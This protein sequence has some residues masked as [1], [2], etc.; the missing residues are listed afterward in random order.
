MIGNS[1]L[2]LLCLAASVLL[3]GCEE[4][5]KAL[6]QTKESPDEFAVFQRAP[7]SRPPDY[8]LRPPSPGAQ[9]PQAVN[10][11]DRARAVLGARQQSEGRGTR[12]DT[13]RLSAGERAVL[14]LTGAT[15]ANPSIR[16]QVNKETSALVAE[17][18]SVTDKIVFW[19]KTAKFGVSVDPTKESKRLRENQALG[20]PL[21]SGKVPTIKR[22]R[23]ALF[24]GIL[25]K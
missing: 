11:R 1:K 4:T 13:S 21:T 7:L 3:T 19:Q 9:R 8:N 14:K 2:I 23:S 22:K 15:D 17:S 25:P 5:K 10:P 6:G 24:E 12:A 18:K 20:R 16:T